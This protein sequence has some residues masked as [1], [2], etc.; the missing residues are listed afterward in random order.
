MKKQEHRT[1]IL[2]IQN[3]PS[4]LR[5]VQRT[6]ESNQTRCRL[7]MIGICG[8]TL[9][10]L[11]RDEPYSDTPVPDLVLFDV[12]DAD[13]TAISM[14]KAIKADKQCRALPMV[15][16]TSDGSEDSVVKLVSKSGSE[17]AFSPVDLD[18]FVK[19]LNSFKPD[20][21]MHAVALLENFGFVLVRMPTAPVEI[22][23]SQLD[24]VAHAVNM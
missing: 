19:A 1:N 5:T 13:P 23:S 20:R 15:L 22:D 14:V 7:Q 4:T 6:L 8:G 10:Y 9:A 2:L 21:F 3:Q 11:R 17:N 12:S 16:L 18:S 24:E